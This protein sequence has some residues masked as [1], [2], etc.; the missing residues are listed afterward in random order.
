MKTLAIY[1]A[2]VIGM[3][4]TDQPKEKPVPIMP[5]EVTLT[6]G[7]VLKN[8][9]VVRWEKERVV[10]KY[11]G[12][13]D[14]VA[15]SIIKSVPRSDLEEMQKAGIQAAKEVAE[16]RRRLAANEAATNAALAK[17]TAEAEAAAVQAEEI[18][19]QASRQGTLMEG[20]TMDQV[21]RVLGGWKK[22]NEYDSGRSTQVIFEL[23]RGEDY[24]VYFTN[25]RVTSWQKFERRR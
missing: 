20:Q 11:S 16:I 21:R 23:D 13:V 8:V 2:L 5:T 14:P 22:I 17:A 9:Q 24:Y 19:E 15:F 10:L 12:G 6:S 18:R 7:R 3:M 25:G 1:L 4:A